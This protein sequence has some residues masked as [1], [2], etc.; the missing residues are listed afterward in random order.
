MSAFLLLCFAAY[1]RQRAFCLL[2]LVETV[3]GDLAVAI[4]VIK[5]SHTQVCKFFCERL[6]LLFQ[7][8]I[9]L[10]QL[11]EEIF[12]EPG[13]LLLLR[14]IFHCRRPFSLTINTFLFVDITDLI[15]TILYVVLISVTLL[16]PL[17]LR[18]VRVCGSAGTGGLADLRWFCCID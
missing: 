16:Y 4:L 10:I 18:I 14:S 17:A 12:D 1:A 7:S 5:Y 8:G 9:D 13:G 11:K 3:E 2:G 6:N 15:G